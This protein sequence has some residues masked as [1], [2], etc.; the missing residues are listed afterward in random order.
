[1]AGRSS[2]AALTPIELEGLAEAQRTA[3]YVE[4]LERGPDGFTMVSGA[5]VSVAGPMA[6]PCC[7]KSLAPTPEPYATPNPIPQPFLQPYPHPQ[8]GSQE[9]TTAGGG[10]R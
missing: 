6:S 5:A 8:A 3:A 10:E 1:M 4:S 9:P 2:R 7:P